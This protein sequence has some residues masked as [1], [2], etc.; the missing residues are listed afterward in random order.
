MTLPNPQRPPIF[1]PLPH[2]PN[3]IDLAAIKRAD[4]LARWRKAHPEMGRKV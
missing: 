4:E 1:T 3:A 2:D